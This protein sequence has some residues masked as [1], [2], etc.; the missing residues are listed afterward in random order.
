VQYNKDV[1]DR[2]DLYSSRLEVITKRL[3]E[4]VKEHPEIVLK[5]GVFDYSR[6]PPEVRAKSM[7]ALKKWLRLNLKKFCGT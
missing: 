5:D 6:A 3:N 4:I 1:K 2:G 7:N